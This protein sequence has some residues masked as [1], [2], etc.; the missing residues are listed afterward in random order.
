MALSGRVNEPTRIV[1]VNLEGVGKVCTRR[2][3]HNRIISAISKADISEKLHEM[4]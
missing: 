2:Q 3:I 1:R 4:Q